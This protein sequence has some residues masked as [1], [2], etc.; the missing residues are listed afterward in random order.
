MK[1]LLVLLFA[2]FASA[3][4]ADPFNMI[5]TQRNAVDTGNNTRI[6]PTPSGPA[7]WFYDTTTNLPGYLIVGTGLQINGG[8]L[9]ATATTGAQG[10]T[11]ATGATG[12][13]GP[14]GAAGTT[15]ATGSAG[16]TGATGAAGST[17]PAGPT[18]ATGTA[19]AT[20]SQGLQGNPGITNFGFP[21]ART[22]VVSTSY[23]ASDPTKAAILTP[24]YSCTNA[25]TVLAASG[26]TLQVR[27]SASAVTCSTGTVMYTQSL[28]VSLGLLLTQASTNPVQINLPIG[29]FFIVCPT[30]GTFTISTVEQ[31]VG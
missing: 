1:K 14:Q 4:F 2:I 24:S 21:S 12:A 8:N 20:G 22:L 13:Q 5:L 3:A 19:G 23:Q 17:G 27:M 9:E 18:G 6:Q 16:S 31:T 30:T 29:G 7:V 28:T 26:C 11:G 10:P 25:T 15:G